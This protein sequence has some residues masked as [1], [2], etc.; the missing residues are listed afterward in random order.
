MIS[1]TDMKEG[2]TPHQQ[3]NLL[4]ET[5]AAH[6]HDG[7]IGIIDIAVIVGV[8]L[9]ALEIAKDEIAKLDSLLHDGQMKVLFS[10]LGAIIAATSG[11]AAGYATN[12]ISRPKP[13]E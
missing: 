4:N 8:S 10:F 12:R 5:E 11:T 13:K 7:Q 9:V 6:E 2:E 1:P 3:L